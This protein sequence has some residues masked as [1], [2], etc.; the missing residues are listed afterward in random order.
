MVGSTAARLFHELGAKILA[1][2]DHT[3]TIHNEHRLD[4]PELL[5]QGSRA[6]GGFGFEKG[7][8]LDPSKFWRL[9]TDVLIPAALQGQNTG[10]N[11]TEINAKVVVEGA[12][13]PTTP[14][15]ND[16]LFD[17]GMLVVHDVVANAGGVTV[18]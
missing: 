11:A 9:R 12:N 1:V 14:E 16:I 7:E 6:G 3:G 17:R 15:A 18:S 5:A 8:A 2:Q 13:D 10:A 4:V